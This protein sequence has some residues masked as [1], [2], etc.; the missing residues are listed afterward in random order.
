MRTF[1]PSRCI[2]T[3]CANER[4]QRRLMTRHRQHSQRTLVVSR[5]QPNRA[6]SQQ[7]AL[8]PNAVQPCLIVLEK[9]SAAPATNER[10][11]DRERQ[12]LR[13]QEEASGASL[14]YHR[15]PEIGPSRKPPLMPHS[16]W[17]SRCTRPRETP[18]CMTSS[19]ANKINL[20]RS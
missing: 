10:A 4:S 16:V 8:S 5:C 2:A 17:S 7:S 15:M 13:L 6:R 20:I 14:H 9:R 12:R 18:K 1:P 11:P 19:A 3:T